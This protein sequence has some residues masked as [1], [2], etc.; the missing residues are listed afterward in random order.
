MHNVRFLCC[1]LA[2]LLFAST[3][4]GGIVVVDPAPDAE[5]DPIT[6]PAPGEPLPPI[7]DDATNGEIVLVAAGGG[8]AGVD[9][10][11]GCLQEGDP[12]AG[13]G[14]AGGPVGGEEQDGRPNNALQMNS[15]EGGGAKQSAG[16]AA[17]ISDDQNP[18]G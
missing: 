4:C 8:G 13:A 11:H 10:C 18:Y 12:V 16:G 15:G 1:F 6:E 14:G 9:G 2:A 3:G 7:A 5:P 17:G